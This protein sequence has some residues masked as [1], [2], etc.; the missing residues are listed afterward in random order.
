MPK[1]QL[2]QN[3]A[4]LRQHY[5]DLPATV[6]RLDDFL[7]LLE[8]LPFGAQDLLECDLALRQK[9]ASSP[10][11]ALVMDC[12]GVL[13][14]GQMI[15]SKM[16]DEI[17]N[18]NAKDGL[19]VKRL[20]QAGVHTAII[21]AGRPTGLVE[22]R[23]AMMQ[24]SEVYVG[25]RPKWEVLQEWLPRWQLSPQE[26]AYIGDDLSDLEVMAQVGCSF[27]P[28]NAVQAVREKANVVLPVAGGQGCVRFLID[29]YL[30]PA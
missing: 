28:A 6:E 1:A 3:L 4:Y 26:V 21:S 15:F 2:L 20:R 17:K 30:L 24:V 11:K 23:A 25:S 16:G 5:P 19:G 8:R 10:I 18:F 29:H 7:E 22:A 14:D 9:A 27:C 13:T 12:D